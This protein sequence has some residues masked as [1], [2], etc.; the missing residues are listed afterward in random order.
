MTKLSEYMKKPEKRKTKKNSFKQ[1]KLPSQ[2]PK[3]KK[4]DEDIREVRQADYWAKRKRNIH[5]RESPAP[6]E[7]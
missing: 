4:R 7:V 5:K 3:E 2:E 6:K 1:F